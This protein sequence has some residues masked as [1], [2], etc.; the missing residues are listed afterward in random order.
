M[1]LVKTLPPT[2]TEIG[3]VDCG[4]GDKGGDALLWLAETFLKLQG[5]CIEKTASR[6]NVTL[7]KVNLVENEMGSLLFCEK[8]GRFFHLK[9]L[10][11]T[12][13]MAYFK[14]VIA[15][16]CSLQMIRNSTNKRR[17]AKPYTPSP[18]RLNVRRINSRKE[19]N[20][21]CG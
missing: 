5:L 19:I 20:L 21:P 4:I 8:V 9:C 15:M 6:M 17:A 16:L 3:L 1:I 13:K 14:Q 10:L 2:L 7:D 18:Q 12:C 11:W